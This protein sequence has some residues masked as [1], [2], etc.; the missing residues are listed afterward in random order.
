MASLLR[1][2]LDAAAGVRGAAEKAA[3]GIFVCAILYK[4]RLARATAPRLA[5]PSEKGLA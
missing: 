2:L 1:R 5:P 3:R 4:K